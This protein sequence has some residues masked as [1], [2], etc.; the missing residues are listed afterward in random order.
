MTVVEFDR[1]MEKVSNKEVT[2][3][4]D[5]FNKTVEVVYAN[6]N[7]MFLGQSDACD[8]IDFCEKRKNGLP[9]E[10]HSETEREM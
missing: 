6:G 8:F 4:S 5:I 3:L 2:L 10:E 1:I 7:R 9:L